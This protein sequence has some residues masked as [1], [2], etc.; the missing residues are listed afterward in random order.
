MEAGASAGMRVKAEGSRGGDF[1][2]IWYQLD[3]IWYIIVSTD[4]HVYCK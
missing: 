2:K 1:G 4:V 3:H